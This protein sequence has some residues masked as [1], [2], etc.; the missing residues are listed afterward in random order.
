[1]NVL[2]I[3]PVPPPR[4]QILRYQQGIGSISAVLKRAGHSTG[5]RH[6]PLAIL[7]PFNE[8]INRQVAADAG[9]EALGLR[10]EAGR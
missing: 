10:G 7:S 5:R 3:Y 9:E 2:F 8:Y 6:L 4:F 1:M